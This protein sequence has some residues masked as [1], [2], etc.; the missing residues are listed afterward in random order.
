MLL[1]ESFKNIED[2]CLHYGIENYTINPDG[3]IDVNGDVNFTSKVLSFLPL[4]FRRVDGSFFCGNNILESLDGAPEWVSGD[5]HCYDN[6]L[7]TLEGGPNEVGGYF[8]C[9]YNQLT[10]LKGSPEEVGGGFNCCNIKTTKKKLISIEGS[11]KYVDGT[12][13]C[14]YNEITSLE[15]GP[16][17]VG[18]D[19]I[20]SDNPIHSVYKLFPDYKSFMDSLDYGYL[21]GMDII[22]FRLIQA[23]EEHY[24]KSEYKIPDYLRKFISND[25]YRFI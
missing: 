19:F 12:F 5:F 1:F 14:S 16:K 15:G 9:S 13:N 21:R 22:E 6:E 11:P 24:N 4:N 23:L 8:N 2:I 18:G 17:E 10:T 25:G 3:S 20:C 7:T